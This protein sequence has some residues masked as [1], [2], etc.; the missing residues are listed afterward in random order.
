MKYQRILEA[1][2]EVPWAIS[3]SKLDQIIGVVEAR[4]AGVQVTAAEI[5]A[6]EKRRKKY[7]GVNGRVAVLPLHGTISQRFGMMTYSSGGTSADEFGRAF[8]EA[9]ANAEVGAIVI[10]CDSGG[11]SVYGIQEL[12]DKIFNARGTKPIIAVVNSECFSACYWLAAQADEIVITP[13]GCAGSIGVVTVHFD[14][15]AWNEEVAKVKVT[16]VH[17]GRY[18]VEGNGDEALGDEARA[19]MQKHVDAY[20]DA[21]LKAVARGR[22]TTPNDVRKNFGEG[23]IFMAAEA[24]S[25][26]MADR[27]A[28]FESVVAD[29]NASR[30]AKPGRQAAARRRLELERKRFPPRSDAAEKK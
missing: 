5:E 25:I 4:A 11:G 7:A 21:F 29:L 3:T 19:E 27:V 26:R 30:K 22:G 24:V 14:Y 23:R 20:Y 13:G 28:S 12:G 1:I 17:A 18:K 2:A 16:Y 10:D 15:S 9:I 8:D 6:I